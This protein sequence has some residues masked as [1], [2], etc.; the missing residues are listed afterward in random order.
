MSGLRSCLLLLCL[1]PFSSAPGQS[2]TDSQRVFLLQEEA[3]PDPARL[4]AALADRDLLPV[5][6]QI[7]PNY[8][9]PDL[10]ASTRTLLQEG[11]ADTRMWAISASIA[12][13]DDSPETRA[14]LSRL[15]R[16]RNDFVRS[17][18]AAYFLAMGEGDD[19]PTLDAD[20][21]WGDA[22]TR[23]VLAAAK[24]TVAW[25]ASQPDS[26]QSPASDTPLADAARLIM[27]HPGRGGREAGRELLRN[28]GAWEPYKKFHTP[29]PPG[30][31]THGRARLALAVATT[32]LPMEGVR[33]IAG[34]PPAR[35][36]GSRPTEELDL[37]ETDMLPMADRVMP[38]MRKHEAS[39]NR[40]FGKAVRTGRGQRVHVGDDHGWYHPAQPVVAIA[41]GK[42]R[43]VE[44]GNPTFGGLV[45]IEHS[46]QDG[47]LF[48]SLYGHLG[49][50][51][52]VREGMSVAIGQLVGVLGR[53][54]TWEN[55]GYQLHHHF[56][57]HEGPYGRGEWVTGYLGPEAFA[58]DT[59]GW[60]DPL[61]F[62]REFR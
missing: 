38:P 43:L 17:A 14:I 5:A 15:L 37:E 47:S 39:S 55:G 57:I 13:W 30:L 23:S 49:P 22:W 62:L 18:A 35:W 3:G 40:F 9:H 7:L 59:H 46:R 29:Q 45:I 1:L 31:A 12:Q 33:R 27:N 53:S 51:I 6:V 16:D 10:R 25:R 26:A 8:H 32:G 34:E 54:Y 20:D 24:Q 44:I 19:L 42:V 4:Q 61:R 41:T 48:C 28:D 56:G 36:F 52:M 21:G 11:N 50:L 2:L 58:A 60:V